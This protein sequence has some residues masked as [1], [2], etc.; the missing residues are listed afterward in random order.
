MSDTAPLAT[1][2]QDASGMDG[3][4]QQV[5]VLRQEVS[6]LP[7]GDRHRVDEAAGRL[8]AIARG[9]GGVHG[10]LALAVVAAEE[11]VRNNAPEEGME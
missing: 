1:S 11:M 4:R 5:R 10:R 2:G 9:F 6:R 7:A 8:R 3:L